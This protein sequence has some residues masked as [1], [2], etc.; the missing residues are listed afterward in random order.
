MFLCHDPETAGAAAARA[1]ARTADRAGAGSCCDVI[2]AEERHRRQQGSV[3]LRQ[4]DKLR[5]PQ[6]EATLLK[7]WDLGFLI[8]SAFD[9][10]F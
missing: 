10:Y 8:S 9:V 6:G 5:R 2:C 4:Q 3:R 7:S 1:A